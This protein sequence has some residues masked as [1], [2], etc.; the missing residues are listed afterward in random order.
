MKR[1]FFSLMVAACAAL[2]SVSGLTCCGGGGGGGGDTAGVVTLEQFERGTK[3]FRITGGAALF[4]IYPVMAAEYE[5]MVEDLGDGQTIGETKVICTIEG[6]QAEVT[7]RITGWNGNVPEAG[8]MDDPNS[9]GLSISFEDT[10]ALKDIALCQKL[11][12]PVDAH[13]FSLNSVWIAL[14]FSP[15]GAHKCDVKS[16]YQ[17][18]ESASGELK[19]N[20][21]LIENASFGVIRK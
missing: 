2:F 3:G 7:Y 6:Y 4:E 10:K 8:S 14:K 17:H 20:D 5:D 11:N 12:G 15:D 13:S 18:K 9:T 21:Y 19:T 1:K 16:S